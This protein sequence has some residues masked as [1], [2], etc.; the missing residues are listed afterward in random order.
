MCGTSRSEDGDVTEN[1]GNNDV[2]I[3]KINNAGEIEWQKNYGGENFDKAQKIIEISDGYIFVG[4]TSSQTG[5]VTGLHGDETDMWV[6]K[7]STE[8]ELIWQKQLE[9]LGMTLDI[10]LLN[11]LM[12]CI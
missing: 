2:W 3:M 7:I 9:R 5:D 1:Y 10:Q 11:F 6:V 4:S 12:E 8:G